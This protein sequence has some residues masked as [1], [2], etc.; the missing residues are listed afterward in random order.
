VPLT[1]YSSEG[2][3]KRF[4]NDWYR[5][6]IQTTMESMTKPTKTLKERIDNFVIYCT[7]G[8]TNG[9]A[10]GINFAILSIERRDG[11]YRNI[12][13]FKKVIFF[14]AVA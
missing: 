8:I 6:V 4:F 11:G 5:T 7:H 13:N 14:T 10:K 3:A 1:G 12:A 9:M 2:N